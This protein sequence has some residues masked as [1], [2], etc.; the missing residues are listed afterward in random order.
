MVK[1]AQNGGAQ[2]IKLYCDHTHS[3]NAMR[4]Y[5]KFGFEVQWCYYITITLQ[6]TAIMLQ[7]HWQPSQTAESG[8]AN[9]KLMHTACIAVGVVVEPVEV[10][11]EVEAVETHSSSRVSSDDAEPLVGSSVQ[12]C[13]RGRFPKRRRSAVDHPVA[14]PASGRLLRPVEVEVEVETVEKEEPLLVGRFPKRHCS[15]MNR[16][17]PGPASG[18]LPRPVEVEVEADAPSTS[19]ICLI[20]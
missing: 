18:R 2:S 17:V 1:V 14:S 9:Q 13:A 8:G 15:A 19:R 16:F 5:K 20:W 6:Y 12:A 4:L 10:D 7:L 3:E 11:V